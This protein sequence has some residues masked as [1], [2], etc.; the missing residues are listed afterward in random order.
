M[1][2]SESLAERKAEFDRELR[3][4]GD[5][6]R[7]GVKILAGTDTPNPWVFPGTSL[8]EELGLLVKAGL[9]PAESLRAATLRPAEFFDAS[10][11]LGTVSAGKMA[12]LVLLSSDP[13]ADITNTRRIDAVMVD[14]R[15]YDTQD[16]HKMTATAREH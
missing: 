12:D 10:N 13:L 5:M 3:L 14:G 1:H 4:A 6:H 15:L 11:R 2:P 9:T 7:A 8:H 16:L